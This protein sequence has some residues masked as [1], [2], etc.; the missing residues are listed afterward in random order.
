MSLLGLLVEQLPVRRRGR[1]TKRLPKVQRLGPFL[2]RRLAAAKVRRLQ[3]FSNDGGKSQ[4]EAA[5]NA[6]AD[7]AAAEG[8]FT[9]KNSGDEWIHFAVD[10]TDGFLDAVG[11]LV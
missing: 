1:K 10:E 8:I 6:R 9:L 7:E 11:N 4:L 2:G 3:V 5:W